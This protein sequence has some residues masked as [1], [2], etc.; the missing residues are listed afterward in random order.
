MC[1][2]MRRDGCLRISTGKDLPQVADIF[3]EEMAPDFLVAASTID[4]LIG[5][6][7]GSVAKQVEEL[8]DMTPIII[9]TV[10]A[11][12]IL[13]FCAYIRR[14]LYPVTSFQA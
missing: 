13:R 11:V 6:Q 10:M 1:V 8:N 14:W 3:R 2:L 4:D 7:V 9:N 12:I 5:L